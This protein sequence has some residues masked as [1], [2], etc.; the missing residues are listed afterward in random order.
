[1]FAHKW[2]IKNAGDEALDM[3]EKAFEWLA[4]QLGGPDAV[5]GAVEKVDGLLVG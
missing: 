5:K 3:R 1:M 4:E 2:L